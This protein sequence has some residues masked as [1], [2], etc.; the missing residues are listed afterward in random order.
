QLQAAKLAEQRSQD[1]I[2][3]LKLELAQ[4]FN[5]V[6]TVT[7]RW[8]S[9]KERRE[10]VERNYA[11]LRT[12][13]WKTTTSLRVDLDAERHRS[14]SLLID[15]KKLEVEFG[16]REKAAKAE[17]ENERLRYREL[18]RSIRIQGPSAVEKKKQELQA[19]VG[20]PVAVRHIGK[21]G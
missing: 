16:L 7:E 20:A 13:S 17:L 11:D 21:L 12:V 18:E 10:N 5:D 3:T 15:N 19:K 8:R 2:K 9:E 1:Q 14:E 4:V 6:Q